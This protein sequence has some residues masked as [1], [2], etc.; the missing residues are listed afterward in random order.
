MP[1][2]KEQLYIKRVLREIQR[3]EDDAYIDTKIKNEITAKIKALTGGD[4]SE[5]AVELAL[6]QLGPASKLGKEYKKEYRFS[7]ERI[8]GFL[9]FNRFF[10]NMSAPALILIAALAVFRMFPLSE[11][12]AYAVCA[13]AGV[14][15]GIIA[16]TAFYKAVYAVLTAALPSFLLIFYPLKDALSARL[17]YGVPF[18]RE[19]FGYSNHTVLFIILFSVLAY[20][21]TVSWLH[22]KF[23]FRKFNYRYIHAELVFFVLAVLAGFTVFA[24]DLKKS[25]DAEASILLDKLGEQYEIY[26]ESGNMPD[27]LPALGDEASRLSELYG[28]IYLS[29][30]KLTSN[31][32][33]AVFKIFSLYDSGYENLITYYHSMYDPTKGIPFDTKTL[34]A[35]LSD[36]KQKAGVILSGK[37]GGDFKTLLNVLSR[38]ETLRSEI[39]SSVD[40]CYEKWAYSAG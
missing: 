40:V 39:E 11:Y 26:L 3:H 10:V 38:F 14:I 35:M 17:D 16:Y 27:T 25:N 37:G 22:A 7:A 23:Y 18:F 13:A 12:L 19:L 29:P 31:A 28:G 33:P 20:A 30:P 4:T 6:K 24:V 21:V 1:Y 15:A 9:F 2:T 34:D 5:K 32:I 8:N 36:A